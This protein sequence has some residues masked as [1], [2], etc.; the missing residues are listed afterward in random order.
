MFLD[1]IA[2]VNGEVG[3]SGSRSSPCNVTPPLGSTGRA[4]RQ[5]PVNYGIVNNFNFNRYFDGW[6]TESGAVL[7]YI[8]PT[9]LGVRSEWFFFG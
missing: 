6:S 8:D 2:N 4:Q 7:D 1:G 9:V 3:I 5:Q